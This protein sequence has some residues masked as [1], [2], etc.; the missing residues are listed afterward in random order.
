VIL[1]RLVP[2]IIQP[3]YTYFTRQVETGTLRPVSVAAALQQFLAP[4]F[5]F[6][7]VENFI[8]AS[9]MPF[10]VPT[11]TEFIDSLVDTLLNGLRQGIPSAPG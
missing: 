8:P 5:F 11:D 2:N 6:A 1:V 9:G 10:P 7:A 4:L 3:L